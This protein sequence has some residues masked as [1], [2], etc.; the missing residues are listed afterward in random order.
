NSLAQAAAIAALQDR[1]FLRQ[2][3]ELNRDGKETLA[4][5]FGEMGLKFVTSYG[6]FILVHVGEAARMNQALLRRGVI[7]RPV[8]GD[9][10]PEWLRISIGWPAEN[11]R[12]IQALKES[13]AEK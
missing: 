1:D 2:T 8:A 7:V 9:G 5:A 4:R 11:A 10:L 13:L 6:N 3:Y 12:L